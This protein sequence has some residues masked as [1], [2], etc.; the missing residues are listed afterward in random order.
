MP[1]NYPK[2]DQKINDQITNARFKQS[3]TRPATIMSYNIDNNT[4]TIVLDE[5]Y[6]NNIGEMMANVPCPFY[7]GIQTVSPSPGTRCYVMFRDEME[8]EPYI[9]SYFNDSNSGFKNVVNNSVDTGI[10]K[11]MS[12]GKNG[13]SYTRN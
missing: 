13:K 6:S 11:F 1:I 12:W 10:P 3:K 8:K 2:F 9:V 7:Y 5:K 4:A